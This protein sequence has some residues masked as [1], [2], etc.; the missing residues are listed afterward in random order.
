MITYNNTYKLCVIFQKFASKKYLPT[1]LDT[2]TIHKFSI[3][4]SDCLEIICKKKL[5][6]INLLKFL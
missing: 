2:L 1:S 5:T 3:P 6:Q 4:I